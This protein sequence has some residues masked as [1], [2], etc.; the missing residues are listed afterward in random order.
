M[1]QLS[2]RYAASLPILGAIVIGIA[3]AARSPGAWDP[4][5]DLRSRLLH[6]GILAFFAA[7]MGLIFVVPNLFAALAA[8]RFGASSMLMF[9]I[10]FTA[11]CVLIFELQSR[12]LSRGWLATSGLSSSGGDPWVIGTFFANVASCVLLAFK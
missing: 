9:A 3:Y 2:L 1:I 5:L 4:A 8:N 11:V 6:F 10:V 7:T 12:M